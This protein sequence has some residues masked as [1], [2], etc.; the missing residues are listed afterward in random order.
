MAVLLLQHP[1]IRPSPEQL[2]SL[3]PIDGVIAHSHMIIRRRPDN[4]RHLGDPIEPA[5]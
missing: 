1:D 4:I 2:R 3:E 5:G